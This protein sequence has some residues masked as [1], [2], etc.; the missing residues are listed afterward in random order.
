MRRIAF[1]VFAFVFLSSVAK[2]QTIT[3]VDKTTRESIPGVVIYSNNP[4]VSATTNAKGEADI[5]VFKN[6]D[7]IFFRH[8]VY[9]QVSFSFDQIKTIKFIEL[10][11]SNISLKELIISANRWEE[12]QSE[13]PNKIEKI[14]IREARF[15]NAQTSADLLGTSGY[16]YIQK[17]Q[18]AGGS[19][20]LR[21]FSTNRVMLVVDGVR[22]N[23]AIFRAG[24]VQNV[25]SIDASA[26][27]STEILFGP[28]AVMYGSDAIGGVMDF[29]TLSPKLADSA[30]KVLFSGN[31]FGRYSSANTEK[32]G[33]ADF[34]I[35]L[36]K[37]AFTTSFTYSD[38]DDL[39]TGS[40]GNPYFLRPAYQET[41]NGVDT[42]LVNSN[43]QKLVHSGFSQLNAMQKIRFSPNKNWDVEYAFHYSQTSDAP[44]YDRLYLDANNDSL[45]DFAQW[46][47]GPQKWMMNRLGITH[48]KQTKLY[49]RL[50]IVAAMQNNEESRHDR[51][52]N[53]KRLRN[54]TE[55]VDAYSL[56]ID[57]DKKITDKITLFYGTEGVYNSIGSVAN[58]INIETLVEEPTNTRYPNGSTWQVY[59]AYANLKY[60]IV[61]KIVMN[62]GL[63]Y[64]H[65]FIKAD[66]DTTQFPFPF[67]QAENSNGAFNGS[68]GF[69][70]SPLQTWQIYVN[71]STGFRAPNID[72]L[73]K[74]F[75]SEPG[76][77]LV[78]NDDLKP[79]YAYNAE[80][81]TAK[82]FGN[83]L[84][85]DA[86]VYFT[87]LDNALA[88]RNFQY[89]GA[90]SIMYNGEL[91]QVQAIQNIA[92]AYVYGVQAGIDVSFG[93]GIGLRSTISY[94]Y[95]EEESEDSL[96]FYP[97]SHVPPL[98]GS[99]HLIYERK[100]F[101]FDVYADYNAAMAFEDL[102]LTERNDNAPY[103]KDA[104][105]NPFVPAWWTLN[106]KAAYYINKYLALNA[107]I[108]NITD[109][110]YRPYASGISAPGRNF[111]IALR[112]KF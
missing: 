27:E 75:E 99:T 7:S 92:S 93:L 15:Q 13:V 72:D 20:M 70:F 91:S 109:Q 29:H 94:Q 78:P 51:R 81:G 32:T 110:L 100:K 74:V 82:T 16:A 67:T 63:R 4:K 35:G 87:Y 83:F 53:N 2:A 31:A 47:Y 55:T 85:A 34:N 112:G 14:T 62:A 90:D 80:I 50:R 30:Q 58:R 84:K 41:I 103:A 64:S 10:E 11:E 18:L 26:L 106:F 19:P 52:F 68:L 5:S 48:S 59:G 98:F 88:R 54:Q 12:E 25:I 65:Y 89:N 33:H 23:N 111:I 76:S 108:E 9:R 46:Y 43:P 102:P 39:T 77:V 36:K 28:G 8:I 57:L 69:V 3:V 97:K 44:R 66:F 95:G 21:G 79:E 73:G 42:Q 104:N 38:Y 24:N 61:P 49:D 86:A 45:L 40:K 17:S 37:F 56:N 71:G 6:A 107:G 22:M 101:R 96:L 1:V 105:G 60:K